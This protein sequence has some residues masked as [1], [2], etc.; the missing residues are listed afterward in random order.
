MHNGLFCQSPSALKLKKDRQRNSRLPVNFPLSD[1][2]NLFPYTF[3]FTVSSTECSYPAI[4]FKVPND[5][6]VYN[7][8]ECRLCQCKMGE[9]ICEP[10]P[11]LCYRRYWLGKNLCHME[12]GQALT[13]GERH[14]DGCNSCLC[15]N[16][17]TITL[18]PQHQNSLL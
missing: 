13:D 9:M 2:G 1:A 4:S 6:I 16:G 18:E 14:F 3:L 10:K 17:E 11:E 7:R 5:S 15:R 8:R 12:Q